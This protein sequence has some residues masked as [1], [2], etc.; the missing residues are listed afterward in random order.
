[1]QIDAKTVKALREKT[2]AGMMDCKKALQEAGGDEEKAVV[3]LREK[4]LAAAARRA[5]RVAAQGIVDSYIHL[6]GK[7][8]V[9]VEVNCETDFVARNEQ[10]REFTRNI[11]LQVAASNPQYIEKAHVPGEVLEKERAVLRGQALREG[12]PEKIV[13]RIVE[14][15]ISKYYQENCLLEQPFVKDPD[16][17][18]QDLLNE[19]IARIGE[20]IVIRRFSRFAVGEEAAET[21]SA[22]ESDSDE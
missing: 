12:K 7:V 16:Q 8:G 19:L 21:L 22:S 2:G 20:N 11:C 6:G 5:G 18:V 17:S 10:F 14:G 4:G 13:E 15:R 3:I 1:M 9:L